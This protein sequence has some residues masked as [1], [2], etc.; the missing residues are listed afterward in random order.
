MDRSWVTPPPWTV[1][2]KLLRGALWTNKQRSP[3]VERRVDAQVAARKRKRVWSYSIP[4]DTR[5]ETLQRASV[6]VTKYEF[7]GSRE[8]DGEDPSERRDLKGKTRG[9]S[10]RHGLSIFR[11]PQ[12]T[13]HH[14]YVRET[15]QGNI[16]HSVTCTLS[17]VFSSGRWICPALGELVGDGYSGNISPGRSVVDGLRP[18]IPPPL[19]SGLESTPTSKRSPT[20]PVKLVWF[21]RPSVY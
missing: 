11:H 3:A 6:S 21:S 12:Y 8:V 17:V 19:P 1:N 5:W 16:D 15:T 9:S 10:V 13:V 4:V 2:Q 14:F 20:K 18:R 7:R